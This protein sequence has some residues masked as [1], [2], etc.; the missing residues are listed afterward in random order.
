M[1]R[2]ILTL[3]V[4]AAFAYT[5]N[6]QL[7]VS[8]NVGGAMSSGNINTV[9]HI[10]IVTD[11]TIT[12]DVPTDKSSNFCGGLKVGYK[13]GRLQVGVTG[14]YSMETLTR[15]GIDPTLIPVISTTGFNTTGEI[16]AKST[17]ITVAPYLRYDIIQAGDIALFAEL[18]GFYTMKQDPSISGHV[19]IT[20]DNKDYKTY[21][22][23]FTQVA[24]GTSLG[25]QVIPGLSWQLDKHCSLD[26]YFD[27]LSVAFAKT[28]VVEEQCEYNAHITGMDTYK[29][30]VTRTTVT[31]NTT[32][33]SGGLTGTPL[34]TQ[35][36]SRNWVR[37]GFSFTF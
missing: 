26:L 25:V 37:V 27:I 36:H 8:A 1:K 32:D 24:N 6:A 19:V 17:A 2:F 28:T 3:V 10:T 14:S 33:I 21:D 4:L 23:T 20:K 30:D 31:T 22:T 35:L 5:A 18:H 15:Q 34:L 9:T 16:T 12:T 29:L 13:F 7:F 11:S